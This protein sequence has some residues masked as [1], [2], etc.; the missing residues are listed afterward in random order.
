MVGMFKTGIS[1][2]YRWKS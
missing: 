1:T 2:S